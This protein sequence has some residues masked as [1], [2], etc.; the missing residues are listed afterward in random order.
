[1]H[2]AAFKPP[3]TLL[4]RLLQKEMCLTLPVTEINLKKEK[5]KIF[6]MSNEE[7]IHDF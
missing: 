5:K 7:F 1:M 3:G 2:I 4:G 6:F